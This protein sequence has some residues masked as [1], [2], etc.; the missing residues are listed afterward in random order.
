MSELTPGRVPC[1]G[2]VAEPE[3]EIASPTA[4]VVVAVGVAIVA[5]GAVF[6]TVIVT[7]SLTLEAPAASVTRSRTV[8]SRPAVVYVQVGCAAV[9]SS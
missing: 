1:C 3:K 8:R 9:E 7:G 6:P 2:S 5:V 4:Q